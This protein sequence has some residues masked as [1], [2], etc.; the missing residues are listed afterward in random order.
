MWEWTNTSYQGEG[1][2]RV[3]KG[4]SWSDPNDSRYLSTHARLWAEVKAKSDIVGFRCA[5]P[6]TSI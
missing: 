1:R 3:I 4:G 6:A 2:N 5:R